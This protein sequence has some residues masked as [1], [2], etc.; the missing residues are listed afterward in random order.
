MKNS[1]LTYIPRMNRGGFTH[2]PHKMNFDI[3]WLGSCLEVEK[4]I[5]NQGDYAADMLAYEAI[6]N[7]W[8]HKEQ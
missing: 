4:I 8:T 3:L 6:G 7:I 1:T 2:R 5:I